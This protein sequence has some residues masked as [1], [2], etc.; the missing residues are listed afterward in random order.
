MRSFARTHLLLKHAL[1]LLP[2]K[3]RMKN[4]E[5]VHVHRTILYPQKLA[6]LVLHKAGK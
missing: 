1:R 5:I 2:S 6:S 3:I 4:Q